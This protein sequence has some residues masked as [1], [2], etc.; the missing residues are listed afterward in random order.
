MDLSNLIM[1]I[2]WKVNLLMEDVKVEEDISKIMEVI[3]KVISK[4]VQQMDMA[5]ILI[6]QDI[7][8]KVNGKI[9]LPMVKDRQFILMVQ[10]I[11][12][13]F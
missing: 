8:I 6:N 2:I 3:M 11:T 5:N 13:N 7:N 10:D 4:I 12:D 1:K 9:I